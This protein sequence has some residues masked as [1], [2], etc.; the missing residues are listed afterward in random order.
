M[1]IPWSSCNI[2]SESN[3]YKLTSWR[4]R[5]GKIL[6]H[7]WN[8]IWQTSVLFF[9]IILYFIICVMA[10]SKKKI[11][12]ISFPILKVESFGFENYYIKMCTLHG[13][14]GSFDLNTKIW[15]L[16]CISNY[17]LSLCFKIFLYKFPSCQLLFPAY[18]N[19]VNH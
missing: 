10:F 5:N 17:I 19:Q 13:E 9:V 15:S 14:D 4:F 11:A 6:L 2:C 12:N 18:K 8:F 7:N 3:I 1:Y 16:S